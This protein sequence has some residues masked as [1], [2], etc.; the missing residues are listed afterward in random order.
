MIG[1]QKALIYL[2]DASLNS[3]TKL[4]KYEVAYVR[5]YQKQ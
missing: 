5:I 2:D 3:K 4:I 1:Q